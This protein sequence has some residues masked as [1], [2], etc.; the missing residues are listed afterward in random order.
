MIATWEIEARLNGQYD[1]RVCVDVQARACRS[2]QFEQTILVFIGSAA[3]HELRKT[4]CQHETIRFG[5]VAKRSRN[6]G[7]LIGNKTIPNILSQVHYQCM[8]IIA[9]GWVLIHF[10]FVN[11]LSFVFIHYQLQRG[12]HHSGHHS[13]L[14]LDG[15]WTFHKRL[16]LKDH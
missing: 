4:T 11:P 16:P 9:F 15:A 6:P 14:W 3:W 2:R 10:D 1:R 12:C 7:I 5:G 13:L 8:G